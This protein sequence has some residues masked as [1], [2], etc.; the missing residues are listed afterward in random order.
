[1]AE[2]ITR[3]QPWLR[4]MSGRDPDEAHR[5]STPLEQLFDL[6]FVI[7]VARAASQLSYHLAAAH[8]APG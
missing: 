3:L 6:T 8:R 5:A 1:V 4:R 2:S 7:A